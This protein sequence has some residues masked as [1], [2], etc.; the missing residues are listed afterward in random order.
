MRREEIYSEL[1]ERAFEF[2]YWFSRFEAALKENK[3]LRS[4]RPGDAAQADWS[5][6]V[7]HHHARYVA[8][9]EAAHL[10][11]LQPE[12][13]VVGPNGNLSWSP[14]STEDCKSE[15]EKVVRLLKVVRNNL[16][17]G[18]KSGAAGWSQAE[19]TSDILAAATCVLHEL[20]A[21]GSI[22]ADF[23]QRY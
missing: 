15:L 10:I 19:R 14:V 5:Q 17:H 3:M 7:G 22:E 12:R 21:L 2:F 9:A 1:S 6:F 16:F 23:W 4:A 20:A 13:Q 18:G 11:R 8:S